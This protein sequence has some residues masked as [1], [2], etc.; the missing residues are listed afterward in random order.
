MAAR[1]Q[2]R[3]YRDLEAGTRWPPLTEWEPDGRTVRVADIGI[4]LN[5]GKE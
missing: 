1:A 5:I 3:E 2:A 4:A